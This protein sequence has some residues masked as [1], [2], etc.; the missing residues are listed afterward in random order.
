MNR[1]V[2]IGHNYNSILGIA[3]ALGPEGYDISVI[4]TGR[5]NK[6]GLKSLGTA[7]EKRSKY[8]SRYFVADSSKPESIIELLVGQLAFT[9]SKSVVFP[10]DDIA[11]EIIDNHLDILEPYFFLPNIAG[12]QGSVVKM[13]DKHYQKQ[14]ARMSGLLVPNGY[15]V[16]VYNGKYELPEIINYPCF[17]KPETSFN[18]RKKYMGKCE[19]ETSVRQIFDSIAEQMD[20]SMIIED[21]IDI[22][23]EYCVVGLCNNHDVSIPDIID[24]MIMGHGS[25]AG[26]TCFGKVLSPSRFN[27]FVIPLKK[28]LSS[29]SFN[30]LF[31]VDVMESNGKL[32]FCELNMRMGASGVAVIGAGVNL[33]LMFAVAAKGEEVDYDVICDEMFFANE[34]PLMNDYGQK[35]ISWNDY[36]RMIRKADIRFLFDK[37]DI[38]PFY[39]DYGFLVVKQFVKRLLM[40]G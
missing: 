15:S 34:K 17:V 9:D 4:R 11:A 10:V 19:S 26:V 29:L 7:P 20:C 40:R 24:E 30:G 35:D 28:F 25:H 38:K 23:K 31:T 21:Y 18:G 8:V 32:Y 6:S 39:C 1:A 14:L 27:S 5:S 12:T 22:E 36:R 33:P 16:K 13:M 2:I 3:R 37:K